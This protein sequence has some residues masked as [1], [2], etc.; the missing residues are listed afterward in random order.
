MASP[1]SRAF[2]GALATSGLVASALAQSASTLSF[3]VSD[4]APSNI[5]QT[6]DLSFGGFGIEPSNLFAYTGQDEP[7]R[8][9]ITLLE[10]L[11]NY[12]GK[13]PHIRL[14][15]NTQDYMIYDESQNKWAQITNPDSTGDG[16]IA[17][18]NMLIGQIGRAH[19]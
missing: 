10:N 7:N 8:L 5:S 11:G 19:V 17:W 1:R 13:P 3:Q 16:N 12:T 4:S 15:G 18:D 2:A 14:G 6:V 9:S